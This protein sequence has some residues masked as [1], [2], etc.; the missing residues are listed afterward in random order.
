[1]LKYLVQTVHATLLRNI[2]VTLKS[3]KDCYLS[4]MAVDYSGIIYSIIILSDPY[5]LSLPTTV[6]IC[7]ELDPRIFV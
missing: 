2:H 5:N 7:C 3:V 6:P 1:M 4:V